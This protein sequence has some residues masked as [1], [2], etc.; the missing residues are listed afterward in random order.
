[1]LEPVTR[2]ASRLEPRHYRVFAAFLLATDL[3]PLEAVIAWRNYWRIRL[4][5]RDMVLLDLKAL[6]LDRDTKRAMITVVH[7]LVD[8]RIPKHPTISMAVFRKKWNRAIEETAGRR[9]ELYNM[10]RLHATL[11]LQAGIPEYIVDLLQGRPGSTILRQN[12]VI[13]TLYEHW[14]K[15]LRALMKPLTAIIS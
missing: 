7:P 10:R 9:I 4:C 12:Y 15:Y 2:A 13:Y 5:Y 3:R 14:P 1:M 6:G 11:L 8:A